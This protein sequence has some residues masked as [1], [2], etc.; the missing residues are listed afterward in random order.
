M[1]IV[2][3]LRGRARAVLAGM[4]AEHGRPGD[5]DLAQVAVRPARAPGRGDLVVDIGRPRRDGRDA[6]G[7]VAASSLA[8][9]LAAMPEVEAAE[10]AGPDLVGVTLS[11]DGLMAALAACLEQGEAFGRGAPS[12]PVALALAPARRPGPGPSLGRARAAVVADAL[13]R[14]L[15]FTGHAVLSPPEG[16]DPGASVD[17]GGIG[18]GASFGG[19]LPED[20]PGDVP[21]ILVHEA[22]QGVAHLTRAASSAERLA[23]APCRLS[24]PGARGDAPLAEAL[25]LAEGAALRFAMLARAPGQA[26]NLDP[27]RAA[28]ASHANPYFDIRYAH[29]RARGVL[30]QAAVAMPDLDLAPAALARA[31][32]PGLS[33]PGERALLRAVALYPDRVASAAGARDPS[34]VLVFLAELARAVH[35]QWKTS[36]DQPQL[37]FVNEEQRDLTKAR[38]GL[39]T[40]AAR[41]LHS[42]LGVLGVSA[43]EEMR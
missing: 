10:V 11:H 39:V 42:G 40:A 26:L 41:V 14:I 6:T 34:R 8:E 17:L 33:H 36:K 3:R 35:G 38:L 12:G 5:S 20:W 43:P 15:A 27:R 28:D 30:R 4:A 24:R 9:A 22:E 7:R 18:L 16:S 23:V 21:A 19:A 2:A 31:R 29:A 25:A 37:R 13:A 1:D 32:L